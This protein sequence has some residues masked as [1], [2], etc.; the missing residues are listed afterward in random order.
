MRRR[1]REK[2]K[3]DRFN[4]SSNLPILGSLNNVLNIGVVCV[5]AGWRGKHLLLNR[6]SNDDIVPIGMKTMLETI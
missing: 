6:F 2:S 1:V 4:S 3:A 5:H